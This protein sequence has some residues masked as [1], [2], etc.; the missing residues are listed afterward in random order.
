[1]L[2]VMGDECA[3]M[4]FLSPV[5]DT[6]F[7]ISSAILMAYIPLSIWLQRMEQH[8]GWLADGIIWQFWMPVEWFRLFGELLLA[9]GIVLI[10]AFAFSLAKKN[11]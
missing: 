2:F 4:K 11:I 8:W 7:C 1:M 10:L 5:T 9:W 3:G 6:L